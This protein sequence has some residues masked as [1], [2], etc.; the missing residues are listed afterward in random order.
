MDGGACLHALVPVVHATELTIIKQYGKRGTLNVQHPVFQGF[1]VV[2]AP[3]V[4]VLSVML[5]SM[6]QWWIIICVA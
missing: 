2:D 5:A 4:H 3:V 6:K 1:S